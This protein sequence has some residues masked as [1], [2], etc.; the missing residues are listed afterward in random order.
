MRPF[1]VLAVFA[2]LTLAA[3]LVVTIS[4]I[5]MRPHIPGF[6]NGERF[7]MLLVIGLLFCLAYP[8]RWATVLIMLIVAAGLFELMQRLTPDRH[9]EFSDFLVKSC[10]AI[11]GVALGKIILFWKNSLN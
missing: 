9:G 5:G 2:W 3:L 10:G 7:L 8:K 6:V 1:P 4:P 11:V